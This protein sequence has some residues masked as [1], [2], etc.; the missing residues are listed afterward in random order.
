MVMMS[1][2]V[3]ESF[4]M[5]EIVRPQWISLDAT[6]S[7]EK[8]FI[9]VSQFFDTKLSAWYSMI[10]YFYG[11]TKKEPDSFILNAAIYFRPQ[12]LP[13]HGFHNEFYIMGADILRNRAMAFSRHR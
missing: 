6:R 13:C 4:K 9:F 5:L 11:F 2:S 7:W 1:V 8:M 12:C 3:M 10:S